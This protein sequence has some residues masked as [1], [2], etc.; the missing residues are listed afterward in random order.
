MLR[1][2]FPLRPATEADAA[3]LAV[4]MNEASHGLSLYAWTQTASAG[5]DPWSLG[6]ELQSSRAR[7]GL[8]TVIDEGAGP[9]AG[10]QVWPPGGG[11]PAHTLSAVFAPLVELRALAPDA[12]YIN[13]VATVPEARGRGW[14]TRLMQAAEDIARAGAMRR[15]GLIVSDANE[16]A[17]RLY[18][19]LGYRRVASRPMA[20]DGWDGDGTDWLL[21]VKDL[22]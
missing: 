7:E 13:V 6:V 8:W 11:A 15:L 12:L 17:R 18:A 10:I 9:V 5:S 14:G 19:R 22:V 21:L 16:A 3:V 20:K 1:L 4:L 2:V